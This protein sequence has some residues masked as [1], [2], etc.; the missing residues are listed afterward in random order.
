MP[1]VIAGYKLLTNGAE[2]K[3]IFRKH[4]AWRWEFLLDISNVLA[5]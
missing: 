2:C 1:D 4:Q 3:N 5:A